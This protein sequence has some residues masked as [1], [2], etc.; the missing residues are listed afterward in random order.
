[1]LCPGSPRGT[2]AATPASACG[3]RKRCYQDR[4]YSLSP[5]CLMVRADSGAESSSQ[6]L[7]LGR[8]D[9]ASWEKT[10]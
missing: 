9:G 10:D 3:V 5:E 8:D 2:E 4:A 6:S 7:V 1:M